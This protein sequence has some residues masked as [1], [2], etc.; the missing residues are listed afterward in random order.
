MTYTRKQV[1]TSVS[2]VYL[3]LVAALSGYASTRTDRLSIPISNG[4]SYATTVLPVVAGLLLEGGYDLT[5]ARERRQRLPRSQTPRAPLVIVANTLIFIYSTVV[6]TLMGTHAAPPSGLD[7][8]LRES[9]TAMYSH[10]RVERIKTIQ[11]VFNCCGLKNSRD[12]AWPFPDKTHTPRSCEETFGRTNGCLGQWKAEEQ[13]VAGIQMAV[14]ALVFLWQFAI[15][16]IPTKRESW[17]HRVVPD[18]VSR[19][20]ADEEHGNGGSQRAIDYLPDFGRYSDR[21]AEEAS[22]GE[23]ENGTPRAI[24][25]GAQRVKNALPGVNS[26]RHEEQPTVENEWAAS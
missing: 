7:C 9:W 14:V 23:A 17:L 1:V 2:I 25:G 11:D 22:D 10:K 21:V 26:E 13:R 15:I 19:M 6:I 20:I 4:L 18:R 12:M 24:E 16:A 3:I 5:R 8:G